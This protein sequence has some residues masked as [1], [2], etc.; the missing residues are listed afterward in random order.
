MKI[1]YDPVDH[2]RTTSPHAGETL[3]NVRAWPGLLLV[4]IAV[5]SIAAALAAAA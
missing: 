2:Y 4:A 5:V 1:H 3:K